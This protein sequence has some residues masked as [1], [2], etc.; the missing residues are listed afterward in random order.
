MEIATE[1][2]RRRRAVDDTDETIQVD[3]LLLRGQGRF[4]LD[5][6]G[7]PTQ[8]VGVADDVAQ[9]LRQLGNREREGPRNARQR[10]R[11]IR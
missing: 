4:V 8:Q 5:R 3:A 9:R 11:L 6:V 7:D 10:L 2:P 1:F